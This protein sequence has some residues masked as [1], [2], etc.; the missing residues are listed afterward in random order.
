MQQLAEGSKA[1]AGVIKQLTERYH[2]LT[3]RTTAQRNNVVASSQSGWTY[4]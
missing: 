2:G 3:I 1:P 4:R